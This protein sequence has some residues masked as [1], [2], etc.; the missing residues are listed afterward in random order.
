MFCQFCPGGSIRCNEHYVRREPCPCLSKRQ[1]RCPV[2]PMNIIDQD[3]GGSTASKVEGQLGHK[4]DPCG[5]GSGEA[6]L[7]GAW[8]PVLVSRLG[9]CDYSCNACGEVCPVGAIP[10]LT[11]EEKRLQVIGKAYIDED[12]CIAWAD[13]GECIVCEEMC[14]IADKAIKLEE[15]Q[16]TRV[17][18]GTVNVKLPH[19]I[20]EHCIGCGICEYQ[21]PVNGDA[22]IR[23][24]AANDIPG[25]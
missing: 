8:T 12:R 22:A 9:Y 24:Y 17:D 5:K 15:R 25:R 14:P 1:D 13:H 19:V 18:G 6:G 4:S 7:E 10:P 2:R 23:V 21:C 16:A 3:E 20:R 11:L